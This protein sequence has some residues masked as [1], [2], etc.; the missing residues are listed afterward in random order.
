MLNAQCSPSFFRFRSALRD[1]CGIA[2]YT[3]QLSTN[4]AAS[5][6]ISLLVTNSTTTNSFLFA[7]PNA[8]NYQRYYR[9]LIGPWRT[10]QRNFGL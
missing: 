4:L 9:V 1:G 2:S 6:W 5:N 7:D 10:E 3:L 8:T